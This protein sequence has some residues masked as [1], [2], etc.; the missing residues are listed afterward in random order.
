MALS[1]LRLRLVRM[2]EGKNRIVGRH[3][4]GFNTGVHETFLFLLLLM[5]TFHRGFGVA[6]S[7]FRNAC[8]LVQGCPTRVSSCQPLCNVLLGFRR[9]KRSRCVDG[10]KE[11]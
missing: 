6:V 11:I 4:C 9:E 7:G 3:A 1:T 2:R 8:P 10:I 5:L